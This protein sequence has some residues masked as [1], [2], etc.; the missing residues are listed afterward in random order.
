[1]VSGPVVGGALVHTPAVPSDPDS[2]DAEVRDLRVQLDAERASVEHWRRVAR[3]RSEELAALGSRTSVRALLSMER[4]IVPTVARARSA[5]RHLVSAAARLVLVAGAVRR[6]GRR[7]PPDLRVPS[8]PSVDPPVTAR[9]VAVVVVGPGEPRWLRSVPPG[10]EVVRAADP[11]GARAALAHVIGASAPDVVG[12]VSAASEPLGADWMDRLV[13]AMRGTAV[14]AVPLLAHPRRPLHRATGH[15]GLVRAAGVG[16]RLDRDGTPLAWLLGAGAARRPEGGLT[17]VDAGS[18][19]ALVV[20]RVAYEASGGLAPAADDLDAA[21][22][23]LCARLRA[24]G[25]RVVL[26]PEAVVVDQRPVRSRRDLR[27]AVDPTGSG[28]AAA[29][30]RSG[31]VLRRA[32]DRRPDPPLQVAVTVATPSAK[33]AARWGDWHLAQ[34]LADS[35]RR[36]GMEVR[37]LTADRVDDL[38]VRS[39]DAHLVLRGLQPVRRTAGQRHVLWIISHPE[40]IDDVELDAADLLLVASPRFAEHLRRRTATPV[41]VMLQ[42][43]DQR[44]FRPRPADPAH[45]H[46]VTIVAKTRGVLRPVVSDALAAGLRPRIYGSGWEGLVDHDL[47]VADHVDNELLPVV[48]S[49]A[50]VVLNDHWRTMRAWGFVSNRLFDVL[51]CGT[52][53]ISDPV[54]GIDELFDGAVL[55]YR[56]PGELRALVD[57]VLS[58]PVVAHRRAHRGREVVLANHTFDHRAR[59]LLDWL[60]QPSG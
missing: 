46:D 33:I 1:V 3:Q 22:V 24:A 10:V 8:P 50:G 38:A 28:W 51:A 55:E 42:A 45:R 16:L 32:A 25:G 40:T 27:F 7:P 58:D 17:E 11:G 34:A 14:A 5:R 53:V 54:E 30:D 39:C 26:V 44:R 56:S 36:L 43:T 52:P 20:D 35:L 4:R 41:E 6:L 47:V 37:V 48:Y 12:V 29:I 21:A 60:A 15:D 18:G 2:G 49:S 13:G 19:A 31:A 9:H 59:R 23:E 57:E